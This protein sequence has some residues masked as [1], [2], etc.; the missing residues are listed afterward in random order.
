MARQPLKA[1]GLAVSRPLPNDSGNKEQHHMHYISTRGHPERRT[2][3][4]ILLEGLAPDGGL[5]VPE[6]YPRLDDATLDRWRGLS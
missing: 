1:E 2:F 6:V 5:Y 4:E 3:R